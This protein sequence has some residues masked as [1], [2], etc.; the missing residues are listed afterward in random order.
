M[1]KLVILKLGD[2]NFEQGFPVTLQIGSD[3]TRPETE[4]TGKLPPRPEILQHYNSWQSTYRRLGSP[5]RLEALAKQVTN[6][7]VFEECSHKAQLLHNSFNAWLCAESFRPLREK[8]LEKLMPADEIRVLLQAE[9]IQLQRLPWHLWDLLERY[10]FSEIA[11]SAPAYEGIT[12][13]SRAG[14]KVKILAILGNSQG[15][16]VQADLDLLQQLPQGDIHWLVEPQHQELTDSLWEQN[17]DLLFFAGHSSSQENG[18]GGRIFINQT[19]SL[20]VSQLKYA[21]KKALAGGLKLAIFNSCEG[22]GL[23]RELADLHIP[24]IV[25]MREPVPDPV[26]QEFLKYFLAAFAGG[27][28]FYLSVREARERLQGLEMRFPCASWLPVIYQNPA[29]QPPTWQGWC[30]R[31]PD[32]IAFGWHSL[33]TVLL[34]CVAVTVLLLGVRWAGMMELWELRAFD[35]LLR[36]RPEEGADPRLLVVGVTEADIQSQDPQQRRGSL[37]EAALHRLLE[38]LE[39]YGPRVIGLDVYRD[40]PVSPDHPELAARLRNSERLVATCKGT[41]SNLDMVGVPPPP[42]VPP[43]RLGFSD[44][45][46][47]A[48]GILRR[49]LLWMDP[50][51]VSPCPSSYAL[52]AQLAFRYLAGEGIAPTFTPEGNL[53]LGST[54]FERLTARTG[55]Y[56]KIDPGGYQILL[57][58]RCLSS[59]DQIAPQVTLTQVLSD[60]LSPSAVRDR[61]VLIG[62][63]ASTAGDYWLTPYGIGSS[64]QIPGVLLQAQMTSQILSAVLE[65]RSLLR[66]WSG[67]GEALWIGIWS[68]IGGLLAW[69]FRQLISW[70]LASG[71]ALLSLAALCFILL[72]Q[73]WW[74][75][76]V[77]S[78]LALVAAGALVAFRVKTSKGVSDR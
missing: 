14:A 31:R 9:D 35:L 11:L 15:I 17:W 34:S 2:G 26:A 25:V 56:Q 69:R 59:P 32:E 36:L 61:I 21:L 29:E 43:S 45:L 73:S 53:Q 33:R 38:K 63:T 65:G 40:F 77:P 78:G 46:E 62:V 3:S 16:D 19:D 8:W 37:S 30:G 76:L 22:L 41:D 70:G 67:W 42:E 1:V 12:K 4:I 71:A 75:P 54:V 57:N 24:Q 18:R 23:A 68:V 7:S 55:G 66:T 13:R 5:S 47:D 28:S 51:P 10:P 27:K 60:R 72:I 6:V 49:Q 44:F 58:Y 50:E 39:S 64:E 48:D 20:T 74:V 52:N